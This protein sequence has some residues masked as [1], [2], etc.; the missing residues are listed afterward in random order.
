MAE[1][2]T[3]WFVRKY[4]KW[5]RNGQ[6]DLSENITFKE[7][8]KNLSRTGLHAVLLIAM[9]Q[10]TLKYACSQLNIQCMITQSVHIQN[11]GRIN[12]QLLINFALLIFTRTFY[13]QVLNSAEIRWL[14]TVHLYELG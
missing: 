1:K 2:W 3:R 9:F 5:M 13:F 7:T 11:A 4:Q 8:I 6:D 10:T 14:K 12:Y